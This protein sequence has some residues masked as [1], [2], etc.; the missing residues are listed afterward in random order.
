[1]LRHGPHSKSEETEPKSDLGFKVLM[2]P[3]DGRL[4]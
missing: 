3:S 2:M 1:M 4:G